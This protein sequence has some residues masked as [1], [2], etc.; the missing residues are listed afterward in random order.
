M[1]S[2]PLKLFKR[3]VAHKHTWNSV[4]SVNTMPDGAN[5]GKVGPEQESIWK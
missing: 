2:G 3:F 5:Q 4:A 1:L